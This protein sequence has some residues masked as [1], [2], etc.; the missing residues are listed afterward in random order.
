MT[1]KHYFTSSAA[2]P[3]PP[4]F[5]AFTVAIAVAHERGDARRVN[6]LLRAKARAVKRFHGPARPVT[7]SGGGR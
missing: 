6:R 1:D 5:N 2:E 3:I 4:M 7:R